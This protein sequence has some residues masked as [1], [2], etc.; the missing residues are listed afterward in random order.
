MLF[1]KDM[2]NLISKY[3]NSYRQTHEVSN[4]ILNK[5][6]KTLEINNWVASDFIVK[7]LLPVVG[8]HPY[9]LTEL[10]LMTAVVNLVK[11]DL[12]FEWGTHTGKSARIF[13]EII[14]YFKIPAK[15]YSVDLPDNI[16]HL[17]HPKSKRG[18]LVKKI[19]EVALIQGDGVSES[20]K[21]YKKHKK[22]LKALFFLDGDHS[23]KSVR[24]ELSQIHKHVQTPFILIHDTF[25]Q[26]KS[27][28]YNIGP[29][30]AIKDF[31][32]KYKKYKQISSFLGLPGITFL[33][34][35]KAL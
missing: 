27:S 29:F 12:I 8:T 25:Y 13:F 19:K 21:I 31:T 22:H 5:G 6:C 33:Y 10:H 32:S 23:Y 11:P 17:E 26:S 24:R 20:L 15:I 18:L 34:P 30:L 16:E 9:P 4:L 28:K 35:K 3:L 14:R 2:K 1:Q 7:K